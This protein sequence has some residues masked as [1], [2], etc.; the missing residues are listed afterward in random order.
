[1]S[2]I[3][4]N[5]EG[6]DKLRHMVEVLDQAEAHVGIF[7]DKD[8]RSDGKSNATIGAQH[9]FGLVSDGSQMPERS[10]LRMPLHTEL[11]KNLSRSE[12]RAGFEALDGE[13][14]LESLGRSGAKTVQDAFATGG[15]GQW[16]SLSRRTVEAKG[17]DTILIDKGELADSIGSRVVGKG[18]E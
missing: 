14:L 8:G 16:Q 17:H 1:M 7:S 15:F 9:E 10:F 3:R 2:E 11:G 5:T 13:Q 12:L 6:L 4:F 18:Y